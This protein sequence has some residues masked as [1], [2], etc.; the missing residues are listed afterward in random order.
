MG[1]LEPPLRFGGF[2][3]FAA[4]FVLGGFSRGISFL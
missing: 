3:G 1:N 4:P 2:Y